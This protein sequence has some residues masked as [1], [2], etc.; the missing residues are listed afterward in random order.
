MRFKSWLQLI[1]AILLCEAAGL[2]GSVFTAQ[3]IPTWYAGIVKPSFNP[4][5]WV[6]GPVWTVLFA[7]MGIALYLVWRQGIHKF[8]VEYALTVF[9]LQ[10]ALNVMWSLIFFGLHSPFLAAIEI[11]ILWLAI[12]WTIA[13]FWKV[14]RAAAYLLLPYLLWVSFAAVLTFSIWRLNI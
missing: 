13:A 10:L 4:P 2:I 5:N 1:G 8:P 9:G 3:S 12:L 14:S 7:L 11:A 6:F